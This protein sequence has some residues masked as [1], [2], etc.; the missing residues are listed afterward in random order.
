MEAQQE[1]GKKL[2]VLN[3]KQ[4]AKAKKS[5]HIDLDALITAPLIGTHG[6]M[7][8]CIATEH[9][10]FVRLLV[11]Y[12]WLEQLSENYS[13]DGVNSSIWP[14][15]VEF[16]RQILSKDV[17]EFSALDGWDPDTDDEKLKECFGNPCYWAYGV[18]SVITEGLEG[19]PD[20]NSKVAVA[21]AFC[22]DQLAGIDDDELKEKFFNFAPAMLK[23]NGL[24]S[25]AVEP[26]IATLEL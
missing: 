19:V 24:Y 14:F 3:Q 13:S 11:I 16:G 26:V 4:V 20:Q 9:H 2:A 23:N 1:A 6:E 5:G 15:A 25:T 8:Q 22:A 10:P 12:M 18:Q 17:F 7:F 21:I